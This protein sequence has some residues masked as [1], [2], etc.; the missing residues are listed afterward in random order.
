MLCVDS[1]AF[2]RFLSFPR[3][4]LD[5]ESIKVIL[6]EYSIGSANVRINCD[7]TA[8]ELIDVIEGAPPAASRQPPASPPSDHHLTTPPPPPLP[9][10]LFLLSLP[11]D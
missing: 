7:A 9:P 11:I 2:P 1:H 8:D 6:K 10:A 5:E 3:R 4:H